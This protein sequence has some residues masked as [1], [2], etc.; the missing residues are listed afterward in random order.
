[1][2]T[3]PAKKIDFG[4]DYYDEGEGPE[5]DEDDILED[6]KEDEPQASSS[7]TT[8]T[9]T[10]TQAPKYAVEYVDDDKEPEDVDLAVGGIAGIMQK[11]IQGPKNNELT[12]QST[13]EEV[14]IHLSNIVRD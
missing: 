10:T 8:T 2:L 6:S 13:P 11:I 5:D 14:Y 4:P 1:N 12:E 3:D 7:T 9:S